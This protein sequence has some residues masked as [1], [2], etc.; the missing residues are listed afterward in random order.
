MH[1]PQTRARGA[2]YVEP[3]GA[4]PEPCLQPCWQRESASGAVG[5]RSRD[6]GERKGTQLRATSEIPTARSR[7][8][9]VP[10]LV[11]PVFGSSLTSKPEVILFLFRFSVT[12]LFFL[13]LLRAL[14]CFLLSL[15][16]FFN[17]LF[18]LFLMF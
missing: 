5:S 12:H 13:N 8:R 14:S 1:R 4:D 16:A 18:F 7:T 11:L 15:T 3:G 10:L 9:S 6:V 2:L 17:F